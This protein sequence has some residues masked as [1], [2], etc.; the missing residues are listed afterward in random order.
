MAEAKDGCV[1]PAKG[2]I[3][4]PEVKTSQPIQIQNE[5]IRM[6]AQVGKPA[7]DFEASAYIDKTGPDLVGKAWKVWKPD[8][9]F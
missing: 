5:E 6:I 7:P 9:A 4:L 3:G 1:Q 8:M 2:I